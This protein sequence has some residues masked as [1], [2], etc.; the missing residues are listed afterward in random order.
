MSCI[1][2]GTLGSRSSLAPRRLR[3]EPLEPRLAP[4]TLLPGF[5]E[6]LFAS[7]LSAATTMEFSPDGRLFVL[8]QAGTLEVWRN[9]V[10]QQADF[11]AN[12]PLAV[13]SVGERGLLGVAFDPNYASNRFVYVYYTTTAADHHNR[14]S[15][16]TANPAGDLAL[17]G[18]ETILLELDPHG[19]TNHNGGAIHFGPDNK[20]YVAAGDNA[21]ANNSQSLATLHG[22]ILRINADGSVPADNP[23]VG[24]GGA[25]PEIWALGLRNPFTFA[26]EASGARMLINDV[27][28]ASWE[29]INTGAPG[30]NYG[31][32]QTEGDF[33]SASF[34]NFTRPLYAYS[35]SA[36]VTTP[37]GIAIV[38]GAFYN[39]EI[40][41]FGAEYYGDYFFAD[42]GGNW[43]YRI[44]PANGAVN[45]FATGL[46]SPVD[47]RVD[48][49]GSLYYLN[50]GTGQVFRVSSTTAPTT[51]IDT[52]GLYD[53]VASQ[54]YLR[55]S[56]TSGFADVQLGFGSPGA[57]WLPV[58]G[59]WDGNGST[60]IGLYD[61][62]ASLFYLRNSNSTGLADVT[63]AF[64]APGA[65]WL[66]VVGDWDGNG[67][68]TVG[69]YDPASSLFYLRNANSSG[70]ADAQFG[71]GVPGAGW[72]PVAGNWD[73]FGGD[74]VGLYQAA[75]ANFFLRNLLSTGTADVAYSWGSV[76]GAARPVGGDFTGDGR[77][78]VGLDT[79]ADSTFRLADANGS[80]HSDT[81]APFGQPA[82]G[83]LPVLGDWNGPSPAVL[84]APAL[85]ES[86]LDLLAAAV[87]REAF[88]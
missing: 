6:T 28:A 1:N 21:D 71:F 31:W 20:L 23:F 38:G 62:A 18:S 14:V 69:L 88:R 41:Q 27:G 12:T 52:I 3:L 15:R 40:N 43:I 53:P 58:A 51:T 39:P 70:V 77:H 34:P 48:P 42:L 67:S 19:A 54:F 57:G 33:N 50:R 64:G 73:G 60:T 46:S 55:N 44:D 22:K 45:E 36:A 72:L 75:G 85:S 49:A 83:W 37:S 66:P 68:D 32:P 30:A 4:A 56:N 80:L 13:D 26:F 7:G 8:E 10:R 25:R 63:V 81:V 79:A 61:P 84:N 65:G 86:D 74:G 35:H 11:F 87:A 16:F 78:H 24:V 59:D 82:A 5:T 29:E 2:T 47:L 17:A 9:G 76:G